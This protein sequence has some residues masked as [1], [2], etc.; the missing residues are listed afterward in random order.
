MS[1]V[2]IFSC[3]CFSDNSIILQSH[4]KQSNLNNPQQ[5]FDAQYQN[6]MN[7]NTPQAVECQLISGENRG[8]QYQDNVISFD[9]LL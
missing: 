7:S 5:R 6:N 4:H 8:V 3:I 2:I 9:D 1:K